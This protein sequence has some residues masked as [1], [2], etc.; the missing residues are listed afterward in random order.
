VILDPQCCSSW[1]CSLRHLIC[2]VLMGVN[3]CTWA[4]DMQWQ[5]LALTSI[6][7]QLY[8]RGMLY[9][10]ICTCRGFRSVVPWF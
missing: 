3:L 9:L 4:K 1:R 7:I 10:I 5:A 2:V 6:K 8:G